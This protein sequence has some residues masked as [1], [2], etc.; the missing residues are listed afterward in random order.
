MSE[1][2]KQKEEDVAETAPMVRCTLAT[3]SLSPIIIKE[4]EE[5]ILRLGFIE[6]VAMKLVDDQGI[7]CLE[8]L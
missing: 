3:G 1:A 8:C 6:T 7:Y 2:N 5:M 4:M